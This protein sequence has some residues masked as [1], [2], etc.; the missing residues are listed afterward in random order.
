MLRGRRIRSG[1]DLGFFLL[2]SYLFKS[3]L[4]SNLFFKIFVLFI[5]LS[6]SS[7]QCS[8]VQA[9]VHFRANAARQCCED[10]ICLVGGPVCPSGRRQNHA[11]MKFHSLFLCIALI[12]LCALSTGP[13][14]PGAWC[15]LSQ[16]LR[17]LPRLDPSDLGRWGPFP[18][19]TPA[20]LGQPETVGR[21]GLVPMRR[22]QRRTRAAASIS[23]QSLVKY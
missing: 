22:L 9:R 19:L 4:F 21:P 6:L 17:A 3:V 12:L 10:A 5:M 18:R 1:P 11:W 2:I 13:A 8:G 23:G 14:L 16:C 20:T 7:F 15:F